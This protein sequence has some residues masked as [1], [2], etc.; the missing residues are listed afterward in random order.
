VVPADSTGLLP[1][2]PNGLTYLMLRPLAVPL[3]LFALG[4]G[5][6]LWRFMGDIPSVLGMGFQ[7]LFDGMRRRQ[8]SK[9]Q[10]SPPAVA[11]PVADGLAAIQALDPA[12]SEAALLAEVQRIGTLVVAAW[13][14]RDLE[15]CRSVLTDD[16][17]TAQS[18]QLT[19]PLAEGWRPFAAGVTVSPDS[20]LAVQCDTWADRVT[21]RVTMSPKPGAGKVIRGRRIGR[22]VEDWQLSR[23]RSLPVPGRAG[24]APSGPW[25]VDRMDH[26]AVQ[27]ERAA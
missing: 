14:Q 8:G 12:F 15:P 20:V 16:C 22:W 24:P 11:Y 9:E 4:L 21:V 17:W 26:V 10:P 6:A 3:A 1:A 2:M 13:V 5:F 23:S 27:L 19:R 18:A 25:L 7:V